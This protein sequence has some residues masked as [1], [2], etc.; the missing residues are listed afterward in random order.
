MSQLIHSNRPA[1]AKHPNK[2]AHGR[3][4]TQL[5]QHN[6]GILDIS[7]LVSI[8]IKQSNSRSPGTKF[9][10][11]A[12]CRARPPSHMHSFLAAFCQPMQ[13]FST[14]CT[15]SHTRKGDREKHSH[16]LNKQNTH[17]HASTKYQHRSS[18]RITAIGGKEAL[19][20]TMCPNAHGHLIG[21]RRT[22]LRR[23]RKEL[24]I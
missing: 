12:K 5:T 19:E 23:A 2:S 14:T 21:Y 8:S 16:L 6:A 3:D 10:I 11:T 22:P 15:W 17:N 4:Q 1:Q 9:M 24:L 20:T 18:N 13:S 7:Q